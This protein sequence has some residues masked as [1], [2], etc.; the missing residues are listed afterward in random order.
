[1]RQEDP[2]ETFRPVP[3]NHLAADRISGQAKTTC[4]KSDNTLLVSTYLL[5]RTRSFGFDSDPTDDLEPESPL[6]PAFPFRRRGQAVF[7]R[8]F[9]LL[10][11]SKIDV[12]KVLLY[13]KSKIELF[14][15]VWKAAV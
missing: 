3:W 7:G 1:M 14:F 9:F 5:A 2:T 11:F 12:S 6:P 15:S 4:P 10:H 8:L 13:E